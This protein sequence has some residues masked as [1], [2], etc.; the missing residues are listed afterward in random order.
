MSLKKDYCVL[1]RTDVSVVELLIG[2]RKKIVEEVM[3]GKRNA[4]SMVVK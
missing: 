3:G 2:T 4:V 1:K